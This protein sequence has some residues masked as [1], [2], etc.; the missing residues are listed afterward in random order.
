MAFQRGG[1][2]ADTL[3]TEL[4]QT[5]A[6]INARLASKKAYHYLFQLHAV[7]DHFSDGTLNDIYTAR[8]W[9]RPSISIIFL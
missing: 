1:R 8:F 9:L 6:L 7:G 4:S 2:M 3:L 5:K